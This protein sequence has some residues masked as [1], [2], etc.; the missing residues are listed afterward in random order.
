MN[1]ELGKDILVSISCITYN[2][3]PYIK[4]CLDG[5]LMQ[6]TNFAF[7]VLV[8]DDCST[9]GTT[10]IIKE[11]ESKY[12]EIIK[13]IYEDENQYQQGKPSGSSV[14]NYP[15][16]KGKYIALCEG[17]DYWT[18]PLKLQKQVDI[19]EENI[20]YTM[21]CSDAVI[22]TNDSELDWKRYAEDQTIPV[23]DIILG[24]GLF[25][26]T[27]TLLFRCELIS[28]ERYPDFAKKCH[29]GDYPLQIF[30]ALTG[31]VF[32]F[33]DKMAVYRFQVGN[34]WTSL[35]KT[36]ICSD[37]MIKG[38]QSEVKM[39]KGMDN[40]S[41]GL[42]HDT[43]NKRIAVYVLNIISKYRKDIVRLSNVFAEEISMFSC[44]QKIRLYLLKPYFNNVYTLMS[45]IYH[46][47]KNKKIEE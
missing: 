14:W 21:C 2:H 17:D 37:K 43:F 46:G 20:E 3:A 32:W 38:W 10:E 39:L 35:N 5:F 23:E 45:K 28:K 44:N 16:A 26:Q 6:R 34:S 18:D 42:Y 1:R 15:R 8:H 31:K 13:P 11:Y 9:D 47:I 30:A 33:A 7:E 40:L 25:I 41:K 29:V 22:K 4:Q 27:A 19:M 24:G 36:Q 12:P